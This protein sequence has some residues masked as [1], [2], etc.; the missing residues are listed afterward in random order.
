M[1]RIL[2][3][4]SRYV[5]GT[6]QCQYKRYYQYHFQGSGI[7]PK[8]QALNL[9]TGTTIHKGLEQFY[10]L[11]QANGSAMPDRAVLRSAVAQAMQEMRELA[12]KDGFLEDPNKEYVLN[13]QMSLAEGLIWGYIRAVAPKILEEHEI[14]CVEQEM[15]LDSGDVRLQTRID[16]V[17]RSRAN[18]QLQNVDFK[19]MS[20]LSDSTVEEFRTS[21]Q[22]A[23]CCMAA[24]A[25]LNEP[26]LSYS[27]HAL[28]KGGRGAFKK[29]G[30]QPTGKRQYSPFCY[31][32]YSPPCPPFTEASLDLGGYWYDK[33]A[34]WTLG[35]LPGDPEASHME[36]LVELMPMETLW[37]QFAII[38]PYEGSE[39]LG[40][41]FMRSLA[42][43][44]KRWAE[45]LEKAKG[46]E[47][48]E[49][50]VLIS[51]SYQ[52]HDYGSQCPFYDLCFQID[53]G[54]QTPLETGRY[55][56]RVPHHEE[57]LESFKEAG[58]VE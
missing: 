34:S 35:E 14:V 32:K 6:Q 40:R 31:L 46:L 22:M 29:K 49:L 26:V 36:R 41:Q 30:A 38:G 56:R 39:F 54:W 43:E 12:F 58:L 24:A 27:I 11:A 17:L 5:S 16:L 15:P 53:P 2:S 50:D 8:G 55:M 13:E 52:C 42:G 37:E 4:R 9:W 19:S 23:S 18:G 28:V 21:P 25:Y 47:Q 3:D 1:N 44:E 10:R 51:R 48:P 20:S 7:V 33:Q 45:T 57:E